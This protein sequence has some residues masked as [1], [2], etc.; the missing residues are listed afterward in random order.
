MM[1][2]M[3]VRWPQITLPNPD[4]DTR[5]FLSS[6]K[7]ETDSPDSAKITFEYGPMVFDLNDIDS[8]NKATVP[9][10][11]V[12]RFKTKNTVLV[13]KA[14]YK[15]FITFYVSSTGKAITSVLPE[16]YVE[17]SHPENDFDNDDDYEDPE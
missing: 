17:G 4:E 15:E 5:D 9:D 12:L 6:F 1:V 8:F 11:V 2:E 14:N 7:E 10:H 16:D 3:L 13:V